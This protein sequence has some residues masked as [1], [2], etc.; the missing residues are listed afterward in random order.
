[1]GWCCLF[2][3]DRY[4]SQITNRHGGCAVYG[5]W[6]MACKIPSD[7]LGLRRVSVSGRFGSILSLLSSLNHPMLSYYSVLDLSGRPSGDLIDRSVSIRVLSSNSW[8]WASSDDG[9]SRSL[10]ESS[11]RQRRVSSVSI[12][13]CFAWFDPHAN[14]DCPSETVCVRALSRASK[15]FQYFKFS[16]QRTGLIVIVNYLLVFVYWII[17]TFDE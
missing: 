16:W 1:M 2:F 14:P 13:R 12:D 5:S 11:D 4:C 6:F 17:C 7:G 3:A 15:R 9:R 8:S 10:R